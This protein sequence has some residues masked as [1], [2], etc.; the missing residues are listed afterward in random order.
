VLASSIAYPWQLGTSLRYTVLP[1]IPVSVWSRFSRVPCNF[2]RV[3]AGGRKCVDVVEEHRACYGIFS[4]AIQNID[5]NNLIMLV[6]I[7]S[8]IEFGSRF[9]LSGT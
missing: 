3:Y 9:G 1:C 6:W 2:G 5:P 7:G 4:C 8:W